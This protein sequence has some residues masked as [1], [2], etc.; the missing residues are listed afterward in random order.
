M[1]FVMK[2]LKMHKYC[3]LWQSE[4]GSNPVTPI[5]TNP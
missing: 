1:N 4:A 3:G 5:A 2:S